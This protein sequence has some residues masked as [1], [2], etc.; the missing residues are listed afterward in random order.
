MSSLQSTG[1]DF[2]SVISDLKQRYG[3]QYV[4]AWHAMGAFW[5]GLGLNDSEMTKYN[6]QL[7]HPTPLPG[8]LEADPAVNWIQPVLCGVSLP[9][10][11]TQLHHDMHAYLKGCGV[12]GVKVDVQGTIGLAGSAD[13][14]GAALAA[15]YHKSL[16][17]S[18]KT[19]FP[20][21]HLI[22]CMCHST[23]DCYNWEDSNLARVSDD[24]YPLNVA[25]HTSH[26]AN[27][28]YNT[29]F[30]G[31]LAVPDFDMFHSQHPAAVLHATARAIS[32]GPVYVSDRPGCHDFELL[33]R[34]VLPDGS[35]L[36][37]HLP[38]RPTADT[39]FCDVT[40][41]ETTALKLWNVNAVTGVVGVFNIQG[42][43]FSRKHR[44]FYTHNPSPPTL[45]AWVKPG[46]VAPLA[47]AAELYCLYSD[48]LG[49]FNIVEESEGLNIVVPPA[50]SDV[51][52]VAPVVRA[53]PAV[54]F[55]PIG[56]TNLFNAGGAVESLKVDA[57]GAEGG[58]RCEM[59]IRGCGS[60]LAFVSH[61]PAA[62]LIDG[63]PVDMAYDA[64]LK[65]LRFQIK[66][67]EG[68][69]MRQQCVIKF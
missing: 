32:G 69:S 11:P 57:D 66:V 50:T 8:I 28:G 63:A 43:S 13:G 33:K 25:S 41:D 18:V 4:Y 47:G 60:F 64:T 14:G 22:N 45:T 17:A 10:D 21:N 16:E 2:G 59:E 65:A 20:G 58:L 29:L 42:S 67:E 61:C 40:N 56:L 12:D 6:P 54:L 49:T 39:L 19:H 55:A 9:M 37:C 51:V 23:E 3:L 62:V 15:A 53:G 34:L 1:S 27:C 26:I 36:R 30:L 38:G 35:V 52:V 24:F 31:E 5:G 46:D 68:H 48:A 44:K 7:L